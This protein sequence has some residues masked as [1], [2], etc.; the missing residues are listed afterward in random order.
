MTEI[1][2]MFGG[3]A[4]GAQ[5]YRNTGQERITAAE[6][7]I[8]AAAGLENGAWM[9]PAYNDYFINAKLGADMTHQ[10]GLDLTNRGSVVDQCRM[11]GES[12]LATCRGIAQSLIV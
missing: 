5:A 9:D 11:D 4:D 7:R 2:Q 1:F 8:S 10:H 6:D 12:T 3:M